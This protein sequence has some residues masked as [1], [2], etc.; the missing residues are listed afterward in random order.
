VFVLI[1]SAY[2]FISSRIYIKR[3]KPNTTKVDAIIILIGKNKDMHVVSVL[4]TT[5]PISN[6]STKLDGILSVLVMKTPK[7]VRRNRENKVD[8]IKAI[9]I[10]YFLKSPYLKIQYIARKPS[11]QP[12]FFPSS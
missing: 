8:E 3:N 12:I 6:F 4:L 2:I 11:F 7:I 1:D 9:T 5:N 10:D